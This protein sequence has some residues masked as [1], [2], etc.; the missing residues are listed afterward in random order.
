MQ[1][2]F[3]MTKIQKFLIALK[4][5]A[6]NS[7]IRSTVWIVNGIFPRRRERLEKRLV[8]NFKR[9]TEQ[10]EKQ[11]LREVKILN[12][13][14]KKLLKIKG[15]F[16]KILTFEKMDVIFVSDKRAVY[17]SDNFFE[18]IVFL[19]TEIKNLNVILQSKP[20]WRPSLRYEFTAGRIFCS[21]CH[22]ER[23][24]GV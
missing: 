23:D 7:G 15:N 22:A 11:V 21:L 6:K 3:I 14:I 8:R 1:I 20:A 19:I 12:V 24:D 2:S 10:E 5:F 17:C 13:F 4:I 16:V 18:R 9:Y